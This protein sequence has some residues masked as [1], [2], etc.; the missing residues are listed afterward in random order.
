MAR[1]AI[2]DA[3]IAGIVARAKAEEDPNPYDWSNQDR[4]TELAIN[5]RIR[6]Y[7]DKNK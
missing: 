6:N 4:Q 7:F 3:Q 5:A 2:A 1:R